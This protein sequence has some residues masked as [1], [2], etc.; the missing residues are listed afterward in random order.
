MAGESIV[1]QIEALPDVS[2]E[3]ELARLMHHIYGQ[4][5][6]IDWIDEPT[7]DL[8]EAPTWK[9]EPGFSFSD[10]KAITET[11]HAELDRLQKQTGGWFYL[12][13]GVLTFVTV[14]QWEQVKAG[15]TE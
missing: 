15:T 1:Q 3:K 5:F 2:R 7:Y 14:E 9:P 12:K 6:G 4:E 13:N 11:Q 8:L 10:A